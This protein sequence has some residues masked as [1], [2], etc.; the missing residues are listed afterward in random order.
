MVRRAAARSIGALARA[1]DKRSA[2][3]D[4]LDLYTGLA[5]DEQDSVRLLAIENATAVASQL[6]EPEHRSR[7]VQLVDSFARDKSWRVRH[8]VA[9]E[10]HGLA[11]ALGKA[12]TLASLLPL[13]V[14]LL[15]DSEAD[16]KAMAAKHAAA[17]TSVVGAAVFAERILPEIK[18]MAADPSQA[19]RANL[20][21]TV[22]ECL[23]AV[24]TAVATLQLVPLV[25][26]FVSDAVTDVRLRVL[27]G[28][29]KLTGTVAKDVLET[30]VIPRIVEPLAAPGQPWRVRET[31]MRQM[32]LL[33]RA[34]GH[35][36]FE[37]HL[38]DVYF[39][40]FDDDV[41]A[42]RAAATE[43]LGPMVHEMGPEWCSA[44]LVPRLRRQFE[45]SGNY[46]HRITVLYAV[47]ALSTAKDTSVLADE[48]VGMPLAAARDPVPNVRFVSAKVLRCMLGNVS[49]GRIGAE[50]KPALSHL[51]DDDDVD[52]KYFGGEALKLC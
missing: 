24:G 52:V 13:Y 46:L 26:Q 44:K 19:V 33:A 15:Q 3:G 11:A 27:A 30:T 36:S 5:N 47:Q 16:V 28:L 29:D 8:N 2:G 18:A 45:E 1:V 6:V 35:A 42:V 9:R 20:A 49:P 17:M 41:N 37:A 34:L 14:L 25:V 48:L 10:M 12:T 50:V 39:G 7:V 40:G 4:L 31:V 38:L 51:A 32:P 21:E 43:S 22:M 23:P